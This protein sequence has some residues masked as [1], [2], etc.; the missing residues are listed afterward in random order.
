MSEGTNKLATF[1]PDSLVEAAAWIATKSINRPVLQFRRRGGRLEVI[2]SDAYVMVWGDVAAEFD[3]WDDGET[4]MLSDEDAAG[5]LLEA[6]RHGGCWDM[7][8]QLEV[9][10]DWS[11]LNKKFGRPKMAS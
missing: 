1:A 9:A 5:A 11:R 6:L 8:H 10:G 7:P 2:G 4:A 3:G